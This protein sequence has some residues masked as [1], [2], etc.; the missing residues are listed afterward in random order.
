M[1]FGLF[2]LFSRLAQAENWTKTK[3]F[4]L[5]CNLTFLESTQESELV[6]MRE[7]SRLRA[8]ERVIRREREFKRESSREAD[9]RSHALEGLV[10]E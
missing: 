8:F 4:D 6:I 9:R 2:T 3:D 10:E 5:S 7:K 1:E